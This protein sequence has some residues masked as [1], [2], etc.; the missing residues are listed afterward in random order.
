M[1]HLIKRIGIIVGIIVGLISLIGFFVQN[2]FWRNPHTPPAIQQN[3]SSEKVNSKNIAQNGNNNINSTI[4]IVD[5]A[6]INSIQQKN[7][8]NNVGSK[9]SS[10]PIPQKAGE[11]LEL[12]IRGI[13]YVFRWCPPGE[14][15]MGSPETENGR[16]NDETL[17]KV[18][19]T[20][21]FWIMETEVTQAMWNS[22]MSFNPSYFIGSNRPVNWTKWDDYQEFIRIL[23]SIDNIPHG[24]EFSLP[25]E[26]QWEY[27]CRAGTTTPFYCG[28][29]L[30][31][32]QANIAVN[33]VKSIGQPL[34]VRLY[35]PNA[36][37]IFDMYG[38]VSEWCQDIYGDYP[39]ETV[40]NPTGLSPIEATKL[41]SNSIIFGFEHVK[42]GGSYGT[43]MEKCRS[44]SRNYEKEHSKNFSLGLRLVFMNKN[45]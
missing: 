43:E 9:L 2:D 30:D 14:F 36:W 29:K 15:M 22:I 21:G 24:F 19:L 39:N 34:V 18:I 4:I 38:N 16:K 37:G 41:D 17:H 26:A 31:D 44:A 40:T 12:K 45:P 32:K 25:T 7:S 13:K 33:A 20:H 10:I 8:E 3:I 6:V 35:P 5:D 27:A 28:D 11:S 42:R 1:K 23:N